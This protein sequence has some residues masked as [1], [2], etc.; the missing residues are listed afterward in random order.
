MWYHLR[1]IFRYVELP[2]KRIEMFPTKTQR[3]GNWLNEPEQMKQLI[4]KMYGKLY[5]KLN[6]FPEIWL[7]E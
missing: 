4:I 6:N 7:N 1:E 2:K 3:G 5:E